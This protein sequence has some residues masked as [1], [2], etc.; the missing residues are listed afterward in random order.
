MSTVEMFDN[1][2][3]D[4]K[5]MKAKASMDSIVAQQQAEWAMQH[6]DLIE[7]ILQDHQHDSQ[8]AN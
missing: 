5:K 7:K 2:N 8:Q 6:R 3:S 1:C 4:A